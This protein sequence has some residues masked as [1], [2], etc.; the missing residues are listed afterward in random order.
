MAPLNKK[1]KSGKEKFEA[2]ELELKSAPDGSGQKSQSAF[3]FIAKIL[4]NGAIITLL[5]S[6]LITRTWTFGIQN[7]W[8]NWRTYVPVIIL[9]VVKF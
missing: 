7:K 6:Y 5:A 9:A 2:K 1:S 8:T 4:I 3:L